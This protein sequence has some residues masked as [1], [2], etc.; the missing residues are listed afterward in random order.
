MEFINRI[1]HALTELHPTHPMFVHFPIALTGAA[2]LFILLAYWRN[3]SSLEQTA[4]ANIVLAAISTVVAGVTGYLD[5]I[6]NYVG[7]APNASTKIILATVL[8]LLT[9][10]ISIARFRNPEMFRKSNRIL[11]IASYG[12]SFAIAIVLAFLGAVILYGF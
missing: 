2:F 8:F 11:Y 12:L 4:F 9:T 7:E 3:N 5:N 10:G 6:K 1:I